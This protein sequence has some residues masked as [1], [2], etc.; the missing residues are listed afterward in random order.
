MNALISEQSDFT[1]THIDI[2]NVHFT[3]LTG[4][5]INKS[6]PDP[7]RALEPMHFHSSYEVFYVTS[8]NFKVTAQE[9]TFEYK[10][11]SL[12]IVPPRLM[13]N[14]VL[15]NNGTARFCI[16]FFFEKNNVKSDSRLYDTLVKLL[17]ETIISSSNAFSVYDSFKKLNDCAFSGNHLRLSLYFHEFIVNLIELLGQEPLKLS[18]EALSDDKISRTHKLHNLISACYTQNISLDELANQLHLSTRQLNRIIKANYG[19]TYKEIITQ[20]RIKAATNLLKASN[21][22]ISEIAEKVGYNTLKGFYKAFDK[23]YDCTPSQY[24]RGSEKRR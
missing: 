8:G 13:H 5:G 3:L 11:D 17:G 19:C 23:F 21:M 7:K 24:R 12:I 6:K 4:R 15:E 9:T 10:K 1:Q 22:P 18:F 20:K 14:T 2:E 16:N